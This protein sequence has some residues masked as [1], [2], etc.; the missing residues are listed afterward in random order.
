MREHAERVEHVVVAGH[1]QHHLAQ[2]VGAPPRDEL[3][4][5]PSWRMLRAR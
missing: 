5:Q 1:R 2:L 4:D 3:G